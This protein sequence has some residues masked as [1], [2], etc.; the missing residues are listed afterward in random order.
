M[1]SAARRAIVPLL[2]ISAALAI[3]DDA[4]A[5]VQMKL[6]VNDTTSTSGSNPSRWCAFT[7]LDLSSKVT[8]AY[9]H[10]E[11]LYNCTM[12]DMCERKISQS[13]E[14]AGRAID[15]LNEIWGMVHYCVPMLL[16]MFPGQAWAENIQKRL[17]GAECAEKKGRSSKYEPFIHGLSEMLDLVGLSINKH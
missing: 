13:I 4:E 17:A 16:D 1:M 14:L 2:C 8:S 12:D 11:D 7:F 10:G 6:K 9:L 15:A 5:L 3:A